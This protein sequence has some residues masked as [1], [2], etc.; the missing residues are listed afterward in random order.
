M[1]RLASIILIGALFLSGCQ[2]NRVNEDSP[3][4]TQPEPSENAFPP[5]PTADVIESGS[6]GEV[7]NLDR[8]QT[9]LEHA[10]EKEPDYIQIIQFTTEGDPISR[11]LQFDGAVFKSTMNSSRDSYGSGG[12]SE[13][14]CSEIAKTETAE[15]TDYQLEDCEDT[16]VIDLLVVWK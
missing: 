10:D 13:A 9:F 15:R 3:Q 1:K 8:F 5:L 12:I 6:S 2:D 16:E 7:K 4:I 11:D 14:V